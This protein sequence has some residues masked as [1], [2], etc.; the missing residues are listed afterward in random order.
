M[1]NRQYD[2]MRTAAVARLCGADPRAIAE[3]TGM[4]YDAN[5]NALLLESFGKPVRLDCETWAAQPSLEMWHHLALLQY[6]DGA[7]GDVPGADWIGLSE[8]AGGGQSR[9]ASFDREIDELVARNLSGAEPER[10]HA[11]CR[12][13]GGRIL[14]DA[15][16][17]LSAEFDFAPCWPP[18]LNLWFAD[19]EFPASAKVLVNAAVSHCLGL[20]A[21]GTVAMLLVREIVV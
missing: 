10:I 20:E 9:G 16:A 2:E 6:L 3:R 13:L 4:T 5:A 12:A 1:A 8:I 17:D 15:R 11:A 19:E 14:K 18:R 21:A 7:D